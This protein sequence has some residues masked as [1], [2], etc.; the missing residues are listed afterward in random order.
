MLLAWGDGIVRRCS[1]Y[2][3]L[4]GRQQ[5]KPRTAFGPC[6]AEMIALETLARV[7]T[8]RPAHVPAE[9]GAEGARRTVADAFGDLVEP[10]VV[11]AEQV[12]RDGHAP[13]E[14]VFHRWQAHSAREAFEERRARKHGRLR[15]LGNGPRTREMAV[16]LPHR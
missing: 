2:H 10:E 7:A 12:L 8:R 9:R 6:I 4:T 3:V 1:E 15:E 5:P 11:A 14:Q 16:H 13:G